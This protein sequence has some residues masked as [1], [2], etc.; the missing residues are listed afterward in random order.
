MAKNN[1]RCLVFFLWSVALATHAA[2]FLSIDQTSKSLKCSKFDHSVA[3]KSIRSYCSEGNDDVDPTTHNSNKPFSRSRRSVFSFAVAALTTGAVATEPATAAVDDD[4]TYWP[5]WP[6]LPVFPYAHRKTLRRQIAPR[7][8]T[9]E[10]L[11]GIYYVH[12]P[13]RMTVIAMDSGGLLVYAPVAATRECLNLLQ[14]LIDDFGP[15]RTIILPSVAVEH[16]VLAGPF[17]RKFPDA[18]FYITDQQY[19]FPL[20][21]PDRTL[22]LP[23]WAKPLPRSSTTSSSNSN[24]SQEGHIDNK[25]NNMWGGEF[26]H[27]VLTVKPGVGSMYQDVALFHRPSKTLLVCD[28]LFATTSEPPLIL[29]A[30]P[31]HVKALLFHARDSSSDE[32]TDTPEN[33]QKGWRRIVLLFNFFFP[34][35]SATVDLGIGPLLKLHPSY[36]LGWGGW[37]PV[38][39]N[40]PAKEL[41]AFHAYAGTSGGDDGG[42]VKYKPTIYTIVQIILS[43]GNSGQDTLAWVDKVQQWDFERVIPAHLDAPL[44]IGPKE[45]AATYDFIRKGRNEVR[46]CDDDVAFLRAAEEG[47]LKFSVYKSDLGPLRGQPCGSNK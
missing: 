4:D 11:I 31:D 26:D 6:A 40:D 34:L 36:K 35:H 37:M 44:T 42:G 20:N 30:F 43:R 18:E 1:P 29:T 39:W 47:V 16:K 3:A 7:V 2:A 25:N 24:S 19:S 12:V 45:F 41:E 9:F 5:L 28:A 14:P 15:I 10:Q 22:G 17:A 33:R 27:E 21:L 46:Y 38:S 13:I 32:I 23:S 8:W